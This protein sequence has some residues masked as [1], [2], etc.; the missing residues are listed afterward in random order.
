MSEARS[1]NM[2]AIKSRDTT[3][4]LAVRRALHAAGLRFRLHRRDLPG[5]PDIVLPR[6]RSA[7]FV[8]GCFWHRHSCRF[9][10]WPKTRAVFWREKI[11][12]NE[13]RDKCAQSSL[14]KAGWRV[15]VVW[16]CQCSEKHLASVVRK[17]RRSAEID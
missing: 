17:I 5:R 9:F 8:H 4:E 6:Y 10:V 7:V 14:R 16:E 2:A 1:R 3:P 13:R 15:I 12:G 11:L